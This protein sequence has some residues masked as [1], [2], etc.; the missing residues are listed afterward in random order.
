MHIVVAGGMENMSMVPHYHIARNAVKLG[1]VKIADG[2]LRMG[3]QIY[4]QVH[5]GVC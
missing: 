5:M 1:D 2:W 4:N 3:L